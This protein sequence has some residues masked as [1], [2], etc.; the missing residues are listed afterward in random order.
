MKK[1]LF[2]ILA[3]ICFSYACVLTGKTLAFT[4][5]SAHILTG[6][7]MLSPASDTVPIVIM[8]KFRKPIRDKELYTLTPDLIFPDTVYINSDTLHIL[9]KPIRECDAENVKLVWN[10]IFLKS[11]PPQAVLKIMQVGDPACKKQNVFHLM[12][13]LTPLRYK[14]DTVH[15]DKVIIKVRDFN[16]P[17]TYSY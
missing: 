9:T 7:S 10:G 14:S 6:G 17:L 4:P 15:V 8:S 11:S 16:R 13:N 3:G 1:I 2:I 12:Y 5:G